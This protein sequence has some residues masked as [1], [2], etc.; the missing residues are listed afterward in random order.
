MH[1]FSLVQNIID[2]ATDAANQNQVRSVQSVEVE[3]GQAS[4]IVPEAMDFAWESARKDT[5]L[6]EASLVIRII[7]LLIR[8]R[9]C[10]SEF[11]PDGLF[12]TCPG[13]GNYNPEII[14]GK[15]LRVIAI[16]G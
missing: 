14:S 11:H 7:P 6:Q 12:E 16:Q 3:I 2:I 1:E 13:C 9:A 4:G 8:C 15:E 5:I 10:G